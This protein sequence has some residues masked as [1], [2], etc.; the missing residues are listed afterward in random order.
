MN[1]DDD[2]WSGQSPA[3]R[4]PSRVAVVIAVLG[5]IVTCAALVTFVLWPEYRDTVGA[6]LTLLGFML[7]IARFITAVRISNPGQ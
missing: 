6:A 1:I 2:R 4:S 5:V 7:E 3:P